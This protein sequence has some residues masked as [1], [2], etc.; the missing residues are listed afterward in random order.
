MLAGSLSFIRVGIM[1]SI[2]PLLFPGAAR[3]RT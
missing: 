3:R 1:G 2:L